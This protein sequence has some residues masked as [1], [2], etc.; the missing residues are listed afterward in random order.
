MLKSRK[1]FLPTFSGIN[2]SNLTSDILH[3]LLV[4]WNQRVGAADVST[5]TIRRASAM[6]EGGKVLPKRRRPR[7]A[8]LL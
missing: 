8:K 4:C 2:S 7:E 6:R 5:M 3:L 1:H